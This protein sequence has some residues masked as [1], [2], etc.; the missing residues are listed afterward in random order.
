MSDL[1]AKGGHPHHAQAFIALPELPPDESQELLFQ[2]LSGLRSILDDLGVSLLGGHTTIGG[3]LT[4]GLSVTGEGPP[5][6]ELLRQTGALPGDALLLTQPVGTG[7][8]L[9]ADMQGLARGAWVAAAHTAMQHT[10]DVGGKIAR[11]G[12]AH[13]ATDVTGFGFAGHLLTMLEREDLVA[14]ISRASVPLLPGA[15]TLWEAGHRSTAHP[16]N[17]DAFRSKVRASRP[18]DDAWLFDPQT[19]GGLLLAVAETD[20]ASVIEAF[21]QAGEP[22]IARIGRIAT[23]GHPGGAIDVFD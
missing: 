19:A 12:T 6:A 16:A 7:V 10:N 14:E 5:E 20:V 8:V 9:A 22:P 4:V 3:E 15:H 13:A 1:H 18:A 2:T 21:R 11:E 23:A 17:R